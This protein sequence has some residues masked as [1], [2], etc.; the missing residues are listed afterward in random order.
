M[1]MWIKLEP[2]IRKCIFLRYVD[3][4]KGTGYGTYIE[5]ST[6]FLLVEM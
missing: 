5:I 2:K 3:G 1:L 4:M 6:N